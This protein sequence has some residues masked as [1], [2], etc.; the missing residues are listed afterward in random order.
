M[1][2]ILTL[3]LI[4]AGLTLGT[5]GCDTADVNEDYPDIVANAL[6]P[7][8][9][10]RPLGG[11]RGTFANDTRGSSRIVAGS[12]F[13]LPVAVNW[14][15]SEEVTYTLSLGGT[16]VYG[17]DY[18]ITSDSGGAVTPGKEIT[19]RVPIQD[20]AFIQDVLTIA[21][22]A[23][24]KGKTIVITIASANSDR[25]VTAGRQNVASDATK[26]LTIL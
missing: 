2:R 10:F 21:P 18:T 25:P 26:T 19:I 9:A 20:T 24:G 7:Y 12:T 4:L 13:T 1:T 6:P 22:K 17:T 5:T 23:S 3:G 16:A 14:S 8:V 15:F 11:A